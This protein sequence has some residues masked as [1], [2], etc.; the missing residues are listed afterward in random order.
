M[1]VAGVISI[2]SF[3]VA[4]S[5]HA[6][7]DKHQRHNEY[8]HQNAHKYD[9][10]QHGWRYGKPYDYWSQKHRHRDKHVYKHGFKNGYNHGKK[11]YYN[12]YS[13]YG[14]RQCHRVYKYK[15]DHY[16]DKV[17]VK[18]KKCYDEYGN[19]YIVPGS[20]RVQHVY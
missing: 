9:Q 5:A 6:H 1:T 3:T 7:S 16:G 19:G 13:D 14:H 12:Q 4:V 17:R 10:N 15:R 20:R 18:G 11:P 2:G 8:K